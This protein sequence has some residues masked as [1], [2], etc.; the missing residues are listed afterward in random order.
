[1]CLEKVDIN[2]AKKNVVEVRKNVAET[3]KERFSGDRV[4]TTMFFP[5]KSSLIS[6]I[7]VGMA[8]HTFLLRSFCTPYLKGSYFPSASNSTWG[9]LFNFLQN[10]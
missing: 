1:M 8:R 6:F 9:L 10:L 4:E 7:L 3:F 2:Q 5:L